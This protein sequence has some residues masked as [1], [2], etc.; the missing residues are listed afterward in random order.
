M[1]GDGDQPSVERAGAAAIA[2]E[3]ARCIATGDDDRAHGV[4]A[5]IGDQLRSVVEP[6]PSLRGGESRP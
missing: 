2:G 5:E 4:A 6:P 1:P 3:I